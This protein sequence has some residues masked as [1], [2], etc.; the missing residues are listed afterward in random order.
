MYFKIFLKIILLVLFF[1][2]LLN[3]PY[4]YYKLLRIFGTLSFLIL[5]YLEWKDDKKIL[6]IIWFYSALLLNPIFQVHLGRFLWNVID[7]FWAL[8][9]AITSFFDWKN[10]WN[11]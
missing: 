11:Y 3:M 9:L 6:S 8:I 2:C 5:A 10:R 1:V 7:V 4:D